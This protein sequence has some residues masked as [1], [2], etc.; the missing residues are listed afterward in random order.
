MC[1]KD[2]LTSRGRTATSSWGQHLTDLGCQPKSTAT[3][4]GARCHL[5]LGL[6]Q[7]LPPFTVHK[8]VGMIIIHL[9][10]GTTHYLP[11]FLRSNYGCW[12]PQSCN[13]ERLTQGVFA[14]R[15]FKSAYFRN[16]RCQR[17][18]LQKQPNTSQVWKTEC[19]MRAKQQTESW[20]RS[21]GCAFDCK[22]GLLFHGL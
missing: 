12:T 20:V 7:G 17:K 21:M 16:T 1:A 22:Q 2:C 6:K 10:P 18:W 14:N 15:K 3:T 8:D 13:Q 11:N 4:K 9:E 19:L 5:L